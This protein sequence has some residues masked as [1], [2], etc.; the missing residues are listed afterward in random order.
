[1]SASVFWSWSQGDIFC[2]LQGY[3]NTSA[4]VNPLPQYQANSSPWHYIPRWFNVLCL[5][6][7]C[8]ALRN[9]LVSTRKR[10]GQ[11]WEMHWPALH[12]TLVNISECALQCQTVRTGQRWKPHLHICTRTDQH[13]SALGST[14]KCTGQHWECTGQHWWA[15]TG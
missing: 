5:S 13:R 11:H 7:H 4:Q 9:E 1:M 12:S 3:W 2:V 10:T 8:P 6:L 15:R 14:G